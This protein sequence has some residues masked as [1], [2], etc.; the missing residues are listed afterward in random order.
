MGVPLPPAKIS[1]VCKY[2]FVETSCLNPEPSS[3]LV[4]VGMVLIGTSLTPEP[5]LIPDLEVKSSAVLK[6]VTLLNPLPT[7]PTV[8]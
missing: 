4:P 8:C 7:Q 1:C 5:I 3:N 6:L 2:S